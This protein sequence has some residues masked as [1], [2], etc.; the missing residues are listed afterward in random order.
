MG[1]A[2]FL[3]R[4]CHALV[5]TTEPAQGEMEYLRRLLG[6]LSAA[7]ASISTAESEAAAATWWTEQV[8]YLRTFLPGNVRAGPAA[9]RW[10]WIVREMETQRP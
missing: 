10:D 1:D 4:Y 8:T 6:I 3:R 7:R 2:A 9:A 5:I